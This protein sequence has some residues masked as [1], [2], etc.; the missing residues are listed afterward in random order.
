MP[1]LSPSVADIATDLTVFSPKCCA[2]SRTIFKFFS[3]ICRAFNKKDFPN[4]TLNGGGDLCLPTLNGKLI[5]P[6]D[7]PKTKVPIWSFSK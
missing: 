2:T 6:G 3:F 7:V 5:K 4:I 1:L